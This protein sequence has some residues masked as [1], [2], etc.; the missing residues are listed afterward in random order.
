MKL[1]PFSIAI[2]LT[3]ASAQQP[4]RPLPQGYIAK[5]DVPYVA[6]GTER[7][8]LDVFFPEKSDK[9]VPIAVFVRRMTITLLILLVVLTIALGIGIIGYHTFAKLSWIDSI[10]NA[11][12][13]LTGMGPVDRMSTDASKLFSSIYALFS[14]VV[15]LS[16]VGLLLAP[17]FH[18]ILH[19]FHLDD[20]DINQ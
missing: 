16:S 9:L 4:E 8:R 13:I 18:R 14:G 6:G 2:A 15:F 5:R 11:S 17:V 19:K 1:L 12:M 10:L 20:I 7:Q 3:A